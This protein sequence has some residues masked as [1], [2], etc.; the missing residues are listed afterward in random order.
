MTNCLEYILELLKSL[1][2]D[3]TVLKQKFECPERDVSDQS[4]KS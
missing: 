2:K 1:R 4:K 3:W